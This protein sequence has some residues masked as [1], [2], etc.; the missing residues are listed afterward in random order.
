MLLLAG[1]LG[2][3]KVVESGFNDVKITASDVLRSSEEVVV[4][5]VNVEG[6]SSV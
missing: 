2:G 3:G 5:S 4:T 1:T 6:I